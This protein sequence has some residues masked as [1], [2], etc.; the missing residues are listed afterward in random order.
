M[1]NGETFFL[2]AL[3]LVLILAP[4]IAVVV[5]GLRH[6]KETYEVA[7]KAK[8]FNNTWQQ[9]F[10][11]LDIFFACFLTIMGCFF[12]KATFAI[13]SNS[14][15]VPDWV[16]YFLLF[17]FALMLL[18]LA[19]YILA[20]VINHWKYT[21]DVIITFDPQNKTIFIT[22]SCDRYELH[23]DNIELVDHFS[24]QSLK[25]PFLFYRLKIGDIPVL[26]LTGGTRGVFGIF[27]F[28]KK[29]T[30]QYHRQLFPVIR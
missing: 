14:S 30:I 4:F 16:S 8:S 18:S 24:N 25:M 2:V 6:S 28:F 22:T 10:I 1:T 17:S 15:S 3:I 23:E 29:I 7:Y 21:R 20:L 12:V 27:E 9:Y 11:S 26:I 5:A 13:R 19:M